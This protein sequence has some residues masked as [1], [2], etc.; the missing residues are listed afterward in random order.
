MIHL[1]VIDTDGTERSISFEAHPVANL[2]EVLVKERFD[3]AA[4]CG[5]MAGCGTCHVTF[6]QGGEGLDEA[7]DDETFM[8]DSLPNSG[9]H[10]RLTCQLRLTKA[11]DGAVIRVLGDGG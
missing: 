6:E 3:V 9:E 5:G 10:S 7:E 8:L 2:M 4:I 1:Q 11:L